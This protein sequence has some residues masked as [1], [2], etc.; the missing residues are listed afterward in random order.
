MRLNCLFEDPKGCAFEARNEDFAVESGGA[1]LYVS[2]LLAGADAGERHPLIVFLHGFPG[3]EK[4]LDTA[5]ALRRIGFHVACFSYRGA[6]GSEGYYAVSHLREDTNAVLRTLHADADTWGIDRGNIWLFGHSLGGFT[7]LHTLASPA[8]ALRG[9]VLVAPCDLG[10][11]YMQER[12]AFLEL[13]TPEDRP[14]ACLRVERE[15][16]LREE[17][18]RFAAEWAFSKLPPLEK[19][20]LLCIGG[21]RDPV[22]PPALHIAPLLEKYPQTDYCELDDAHAFANT[23]IALSERV[24]QWLCAHC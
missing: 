23:R 20:E 2:L 7:A 3:N 22:T 8:V 10:M 12:E 5:Q 24:G 9:A 14:G 19:Y 18:A 15:G 4:N 16:F 13:V 11:M 17:A 1:K 6:W 21:S